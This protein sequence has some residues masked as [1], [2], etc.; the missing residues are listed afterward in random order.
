MRLAILFM[1]LIFATAYA[2]DYV[3]INSMDGRDVL[4]GIFYG[5]VKGEQVKFMPVPSG[6]N[7]L[8]AAKVGQGH[9]ILLIQSDK[10]V[11]SFVENSLK[12]NNNT[13]EVYTST[14]ATV[15]NLDLARR[16]GAERFIVVDSAYSDSALSVLPYAKF[17]K[18]YVLLADKNNA[19]EVKSIVAGKQVMIYGLVDKEVSA[20]LAPY[21]PEIVGKGEDKFEDNIAI[22]DR[23]MSES[24]ANRAIMID[25]TFIEEA[26]AAGDQP[27]ILIGTLVPQP[28]YDFVKQKVRDGQLLQVMLIG[29]QLVVPV[30]DMRERMKREFQAEGVDK[31]FGVIVKF[32]QVI[33]SAGTGVLV[34]DTFHMPAYKPL[35]NISEVT[36]NRQSAK[37]MVSVGNIGEG[38]AYYTSE[39]RVKVNGADFKVFASNETKLVERG[40]QVGMEY[41]LDLSTVPEGN[42]TALALVKY[43]L[44]KASLESFVS[45]E[46]PLTTISYVDASNVSVQFAKYDRDNRRMLVT[47]RNNGAQAAYVFSRVSLM[48]GGQPTNISSAA[49]RTV[50]PASLVVEEFPLE[51]GEADLSAN[52]NVS[53]FIDYGGRP[54]FLAKHAQY[55]VPLESPANPFLFAIVPLAFLALIL[56]AAYF[57][58]VRKPGKAGETETEA[59]SKPA[60]KA[61]RRK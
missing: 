22:T 51:L 35:L 30:Y 60:S 11:S 32:A 12:A 37:V 56:A 4:S 54:G 17:T 43:G 36:Y 47:L 21:S 19:D 1:L 2:E 58:F 52:S 10:P 45:K 27:L 44:S 28:T 48:L 50:E 38:A 23:L 59:E 40:E 14:N 26:I 41:P 39:V 7:D 9:S 5:N 18:A 46:G 34:L 33:P 25:G 55:I 20:A 16:S 42:V 24:H 29:N 8:F 13:V 57:I 6:N 61:A 15:T 53:V 3:A 31:T 49:T